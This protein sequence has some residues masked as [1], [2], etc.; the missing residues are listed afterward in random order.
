M[1]DRFTRPPFNYYDGKTDPVEHVSYYIQMMSLHTHNDALMCKVFPSSL[2]PTI[3][4]WFK[5]LQKE[6]IRS[7]SMLIQEFG[8]R[9]VTCSRVPQPVDALLSMKMRAGETLHC[10]A[11]RFWELYNEIG[12]DNERVAVSTFRME[13]PEDSGLRELL[14]KKST[15][16]MRQLMRRIKE[17]KRLEDDR[18]Q[19]KGKAPMMN[20]PRQTGFRSGLVGFWRFKSQPHKW[21]K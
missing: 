4:R 8:I 19:S 3:L 21:E 11:S 13:L 15:E 18:L 6:S 7:F 17:Y 2:G 1:P 10:Y 20:H 14:T 12:G 9:F 16:G 5:G